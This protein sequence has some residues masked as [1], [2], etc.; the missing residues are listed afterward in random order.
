MSEWTEDSHRRRELA[1]L[2]VTAEVEG[3]GHRIR[4]TLDLRGF[5]G[6][7]HLNDQAAYDNG[8]ADGYEEGRD[9][10]SKE[11]YTEGFKAGHKTALHLLAQ[12]EK[13]K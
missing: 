12:L 13:M 9:F 2:G 11:S 10:R 3:D 7:K 5:D 8:H 1:E 6:L 4:V